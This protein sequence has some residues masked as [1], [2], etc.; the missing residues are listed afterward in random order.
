MV[1]AKTSPWCSRGADREL[2]LQRVGELAHQRLHVIFVPAQLLPHTALVEV[3][4]LG[5]LR[6]GEVVDLS[7]AARSWTAYSFI[8]MF[9]C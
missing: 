2:C 4:Q 6:C 5:H 7:V 3:R 9:R 1:A 8:C